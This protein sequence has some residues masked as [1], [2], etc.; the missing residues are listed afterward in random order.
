MTEAGNLCEDRRVTVERDVNGSAIVSGTGNSI[1]IYYQS[2]LLQTEP[3]PP[4]PRSDLG[5]NPYKGIQA[6]LETDGDRF[7]GREQQIEQ[8]WQ[9]LC[10]LYETPLSIRLLPI[11]GPSGS[12]KSSLARAGLIP[13]LARR[14][15]PGSVRARVAVLVPTAD[16]LWSLATV[17]ARIATND[18]SPAEKA[19]EFKRVLEKPSEAG[20]YEGLRQIADVLPDSAIAPLIVLVDQFEEVYTLCKDGIARDAFVNTLLNAAGDRARRVSVVITLRS[21]FLGETQKHPSLNAL[22]TEPGVLVR[23]M[24]EA[25]LQRAIAEPAKR[26]GHALDAA[27]IQ[28]LLKETEGREGALPLLQF[29]LE[30]IW[31]GLVKGQEPAATLQ[32]IGGVGGALAGEAQ[33]IY[34]GLNPTNQEIARRVFLGLVQLGEGTKDTRRRARLEQVIS[35]RD[36][37]AQVKAVIMQFSTPQARLITLASDADWEIAEVTHEALFDHWQQFKGWVDSSRSDLRFQRRLDEAALHWQEQ[38]RPEGNLWQPPDLDLLQRYQQRVG[39]DMTPLQS[40]FFEAS[41]RA[42]NSRK[43]GRQIALGG[44]ITGSVLITG[45]AVFGFYELQQSKRQRVDQL[46]LTAEA[47][48]AT[49]PVSAAMTAI[50]A[51]R[52]SQSSFVQFSSSP[53]PVSVQSSLLDVAQMSREQNWIQT[54]AVVLSVSFSPDGKTIASGGADGTLK[55]WS[56]DGRL[57][58]IFKKHEYGGVLSVSF[59]PDGKTIAS[60]GDDKTLKLWSLDGRLLHTFKGHENSVWSVS[61]SPDGKTLASGSDDNTLKLWSL[62]G[63]L[64]HTFKGHENV[65]RSVS[66]SPDGKT[67][68]SGSWDNTLK[69][70]SLDGRLLHTFKG[71][72]DSVSSM[73]FSPDGKTLAS[74]SDDGT[75]E[76]WSLDGRNLHT[77]KG[78]ENSVWSVSFSPD[79]KT[80][81]SGS[82]DKTLKLWSLDGRN[83]HTFKGHESS[84]SS[85]SFSPDGKT[86]ASGSWD[87]TIKLWSLDGRLLPTFKGHEGSVRSVSFSPDG[88]TLASGSWDNTLK[89]WS[90]DG[91]NLHTFKGHE[92]SVSSVS[93]SPDGKTLASGSEDKTIK[94]W[95]LDGRNLH[96]FKGHESSVS[97]VSFSPDGKTLA[98]GSW[99]KTIK[100]WSLDGRNLHTFKGEDRVS[101]V[102]FSPDGK[103]LASGGDDGTLKLWS[104][105]GRLLHTFKGHEGSVTSVSFSRDGKTLAS[106]S[107]DNTLRLWDVALGQPIGQPLQGHESIVNSVSFSPDGHT[108]ASGSDGK[109]LRLW[110]I[111]WESLLQ[112]ACQRLSHHT[113]LLK[114]ATQTAREAKDT[115]QQYVWSKQ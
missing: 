46:A 68:A 65:V 94:L 96:T 74:G 98:S 55:L 3:A 6:F 51:V 40:A 69:L 86:L 36:S 27:T 102:S 30:R 29:A 111:S 21:D 81:A 80:L 37:L 45:L 61:F 100:L 115:C 25:E 7:F 78:H 39:A 15:L 114:A 24:N 11:Y 103:T 41:D 16:P 12:G 28:L 84:V 53:M 93:F 110:S 1:V 108:I 62:D 13:E 75:L 47:L 43:R 113:T 50:S 91:R 57:L 54:Q 82:E 101:S 99:D 34:E 85:V 73:S 49:D 107:D 88:K 95:S 106:G 10:Q 79:G 33:R 58:H 66:F 71:H 19:A 59:S 90:L 42:E 5:P 70:W 38:G 60:G 64:L 44:L 31:E 52:L 20:Q 35:R 23:S 8:L 112:T 2:Q 26:A 48:L 83:L 77:F 9:K 14:S 92:S 22:F 76:L 67:L 105:D 72:G 63:R 4:A 89:L 17:L 97:S 87:K 56:L 109:T 18:P 104:L 32:E